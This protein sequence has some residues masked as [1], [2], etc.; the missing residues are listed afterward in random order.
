[1]QASEQSKAP[2][3]GRLGGMALLNQSVLHG[4]QGIVYAKEATVGSKA[5]LFGGISGGHS[6]YKTGSHVDVNGVNML[7]GVAKGFESAQGQ[8]TVG[9][10]IEGGYGRHTTHNSFSTGDVDG[11][12]KSRYFGV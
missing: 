12:G 8:A 5:G 11:R 4:S 2:L 1:S 10:F 3:E 9:G 7:L 6:R